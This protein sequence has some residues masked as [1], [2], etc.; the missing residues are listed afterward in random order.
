MA[1]PVYIRRFGALIMLFVFAFCITP[2]IL[3][4][5][6][7]ADHRDA[8]FSHNHADGSQI[9]KS[10]FNCN[11]D[12]LVVE[13]P[14]INDYLPVELSAVPKFPDEHIVY[15]KNFCSGTCLYFELRG[16]P[17]LC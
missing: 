5:N 17:G 13:S 3:L 14:F 7:L 11:S 15:L 10:V 4:H 16:P 2:K 8:P 12:N 6:L 1:N 9:S